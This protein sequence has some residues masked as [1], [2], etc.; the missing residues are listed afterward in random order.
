M[1]CWIERRLQNADMDLSNPIDMDR[2]LLSK[3]PAQRGTRYRRVLAFGNH[4]RVE[5][6]H[7][8]HLL[9]YNSGVASIFQQ[10]SENG[11]ESA[12]NY[13]GVL[14]DILDLDYGTL[15]RSIIMM[16]CDWVKAH[17]SRGNPTYMRDEAGFLLVNFR[18]TQPCML[19]PFIF[20]SQ[21]TQVF[22]SDVAGRP[23]WRVVLRKEA[24]ARR[25]V[26]DTV[27]AFIST[28]VESTGLRAPN[29]FLDAT[30]VVNL[31][32]AIELTDEEN[33]LAHGGY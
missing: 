19:D 4:F 17:D 1:S 31:V 22:F 33:L 18:H 24:R 28:R 21:A 30:H 10:Q 14:R 12:V 26:V 20:P 27:D 5:D 2:F 9:S 32:G 25:E 3:K 11:E 7:T 13:V 15:S 8:T 23:S 29:T 6:E 16:R